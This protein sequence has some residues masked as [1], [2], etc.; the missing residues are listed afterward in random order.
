MCSPAIPTQLRALVWPPATEHRLQLGI[1]ADG[2][3]VR[4]DLPTEAEL[5]KVANSLQEAKE[6]LAKVRAPP[7]LLALPYG[8]LAPVLTSP[9]TTL[10][11]GGYEA[12]EVLWCC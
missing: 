8:L 7:G 11:T 5:R 9:H 4:I 1:P 12:Q 10:G 2:S 6:R 3:C